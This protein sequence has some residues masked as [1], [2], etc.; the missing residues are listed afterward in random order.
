MK[1]VLIWGA[2][3]YAEYVYDVI[4]KKI[5]T[6]E[7]IIDSDKKKQGMLWKEKLLI[8][9]PE[10]INNLEFDKIIVSV[11]EYISVEAKA[12]EL[13]IP[14][15]KIIFYW[16]DSESQGIFENRA[17]RI[18][19]EKQ[20]KEIYKNRFESAPYEWGLKKV[21]MI[22]SD[23]KLLKRIIKDGSSLS[24]FGDG[25]FEIMQGRKRPWFQKPSVSLQKRL[26]EVMDSKLV[27]LNIAIAQNFMFLDQYKEDVADGI[28]AYMSNGN[29]ESIINF[30]PNRE[31][32]NAYVTRPY[33]MY[34]EKN[35]AERIFLLFKRVWEG[36]TIILVEGKYARIGVGND[37]FQ[38]AKSLKRILCPSQ[39]TW[40]NYEEIKA[41]VLE[42]VKKND[43]ICISLGPTATV[44]AYDLACQGF[45]ALDIGQLDNEYEWFLANAK[46][47]INIKGKM[48]AELYDYYNGGEFE[49]NVY[50]SQIIQRIGN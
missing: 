6:I 3:Y 30:L 33:I 44:L 40:N 41:A 35:H 37:L 1:K 26:I 22:Y 18:L 17:L 15:N 5:C 4:D 9:S 36:R 21:P 27:N 45:Q 46:E 20:E 38:G 10:E 16:K 8:Y 24:R 32:Y 48:V 39:E 50:E 19:Q 34:K 11:K 23:E 7:G 43:L 47:R 29:R 25:E 28:R 2:G 12:K 42:N 14:E 49:N 31:F 13:Y